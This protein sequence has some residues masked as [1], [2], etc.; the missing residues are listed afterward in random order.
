MF[1]GGQQYVGANAVTVAIARRQWTTGLCDCCSDMGACCFAYFLPWC[2]LCKVY[3]DA[4]EG[5]CSCLWGGIV[6]LR[7]K[8]RTERGIQ[9]RHM[10]IDFNQSL[11]SSYHIICVFLGQHLRRLLDNSLLSVLLYTTSR[12]RGQEHSA[13]YLNIFEQ[14]ALHDHFYTKVLIIK[15]KNLKYTT[16]N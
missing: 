4:G 14:N 6:P 13:A 7:V 2:Y 5:F 3:S 8:V 12:Q 16:L 10:I 9:V 1:I 15:I 11:D